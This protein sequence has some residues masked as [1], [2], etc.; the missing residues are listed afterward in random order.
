MGAGKSTIG[1]LLAQEL[2]LNFIDSD[3]EIEERAGTNIPWI[4]DV[5]G[6]AGFRDREEAVIHD[7][8][9]A[10]NLVLATGGGVVKRDMNRAA[11]A[12]G[13]FVVYLQT[14]VDQQLERTAKDKNRPLLQTENPRAVLETLMEERDPLYRQ[15]CDLLIHTDKRHPRAV[16]TTIVRQLVRENV[17]KG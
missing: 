3:R 6:E 9:Q 12:A 10:D 15:V 2:K 16:V 8:S 11:L 7:L 17:L 5:E 4:F 14:S 13:G 1:R